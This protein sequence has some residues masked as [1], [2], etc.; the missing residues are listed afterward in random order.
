MNILSLAAAETIYT[1]LLLLMEAGPNINTLYKVLDS[2]T[3]NKEVK[4]LPDG[5]PDDVQ[6]NMFVDF[7]D[8]KIENVI[9]NFKVDGH[10][11]P[12]LETLVPEIKLTCFQQVDVA[13]VKSIV[14]RVTLTYCDNDPFPIS[15]IIK[16]GN[17][18]DLLNI[19]TEMVNISIEYK[20]FPEREKVAIVKSIVKGKLDPQCLSSFRP[21][22]NLTFLSKILYSTETTLCSVVNNL[23]VLVDEGKYGVLILLDLSTV[24]DMVEHSLLLQYCKTIGMRVVH[25]T[26]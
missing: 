15:D 24:F 14:H 19:M 21:V 22:S 25:L 4:K 18:S 20:F 13:V 12:A 23:L 6:A 5:F 1:L 17:F 26:V 3:G 16:S 7:F 2:L 10:H 8:K 11:G 9:M